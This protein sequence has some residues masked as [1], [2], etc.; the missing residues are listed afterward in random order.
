MGLGDFFVREKKDEKKAS[1][2]IAEGSI[3]ES[4]AAAKSADEVDI[5][6]ALLHGKELA[7]QF[8]TDYGVFEFRYPSGGDTVR[9]GRRRAEYMG[10]H[11]DSSFDN[12]RRFQFEEWAT[13][14]VLIS[15]KP[16]PFDTMDSWADCPDPELIEDLYDRGSQFCHDI[17]EKI[18]GSRLRKSVRSD[19]T[20]GA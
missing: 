16:T 4:S 19:K 17:R 7:V 15:K 10:G 11:A 8:D 18:K 13:L 2:V 20:Q 5:V 12:P 1:D 9:I 14:D 6:D 3:A